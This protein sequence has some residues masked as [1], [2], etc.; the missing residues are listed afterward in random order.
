MVTISVSEANEEWSA[1]TAVVDPL[2]DNAPTNNFPVG[3]TTGE[4]IVKR[5]LP[6]VV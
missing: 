4:A 1:M 6:G 5:P 2:P 3:D